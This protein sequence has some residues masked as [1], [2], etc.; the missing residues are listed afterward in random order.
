MEKECLAIIWSIKKFRPYL[1]NHFIIQTDHKTL[2]Q[3]TKLKD[4]NPRITMQQLFLQNYN[5]EIQHIK[6]VD[7]I[8]ADSLS[9]SF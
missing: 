2:T 1:C 4:T 6:G 7:N 3:M 9:R 8:L 5:Y